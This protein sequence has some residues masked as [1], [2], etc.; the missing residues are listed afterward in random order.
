MPNENISEPSTGSS[1]SGLPVHKISILGEGGTYETQDPEARTTAET[2]MLSAQAANDKFP[3]SIENGG[4]GATSVYPTKEAGED[5]ATAKKGVR[6]LME[7]EYDAQLVLGIYKGRDL[8]EVFA[9]EI[10]DYT[11]DAEWF[12]ARINAGDFTGIRIF[13]HFDITLTDNKVFRYRVAAIDPYFHCND[14]A[15]TK[16]HIIMVPD[17]VWPDSVV[18]NTTSTNQGTA[19]ENHP[20]LASNLHRWEINTFYPLM[21]TQWKNVMATHRLMLEERYSASGSLTSSNSWSWVDVGKIFS[22]SETEVY[23][24]IA[25]GSSLYSIGADCHFDTFFKHSKHR[26]RQ[27]YSGQRSSWWL[28][29]ASNSQTSAC[30]VHHSGLASA[31]N[32]SGSGF[33]ALPCFRVGV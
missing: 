33:Y 30:N 19:S 21:P 27:N 2:A 9:N 17:Q 7:I 5:S 14:N 10:A 26:I 8:N 28:R 22:L 18:W 32:A 4:T 11:S 1:T 3:V 31:Y 16:H 25:Y 29:N 24:Q 12:N 15:I 23:G 13:D 20:Y 6:D